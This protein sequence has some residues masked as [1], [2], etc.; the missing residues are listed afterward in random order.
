MPRA[1]ISWS[2]GKDSVWALR[3]AREAGIEPVA[4]ITT[5]NQATAHIPVHHVPLHLI[6]AQAETLG[7]PLR[8]V[9][10]PWPCNNEEYL[11][12]VGAALASAAL[13]GIDTIVF[14]DIHLADIRAFREHALAGTGLAPV[15]PLWGMD[16]AQLAHEMIASG[17]NATIAAVDERVLPASF[18]GRPYDA[19]FLADLPP[20]VDPCG[21]NGE[22]HTMVQLAAGCAKF[23]VRN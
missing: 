1:L 13:E 10:L 19:A 22:F 18:I 6:Q 12:R 17:M 9:P 2:G 14:G 4:L 16:S 15:F 20:A 3:R 23:H 21:E 7:L 11:L 8:P 5:F